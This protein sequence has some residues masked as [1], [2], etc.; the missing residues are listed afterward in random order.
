[1]Q[2]SCWIGHRQRGNVLNIYT[3]LYV[4]LQQNIAILKY[5]EF[6]TTTTGFTNDV[7]KNYVRRAV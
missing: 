6:V 1:M 7:I 5:L 2:R 3:M 4:L